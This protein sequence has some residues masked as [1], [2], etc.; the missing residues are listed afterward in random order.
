MFKKVTAIFLTFLINSFVFVNFCDANAMSYKGETYSKSLYLVN[1]DTGKVVYEKNARERLAPAST[2]KIMTYIVAVENCKDLN[3]TMVTVTQDITDK[4]RG[5]ESS[6]AGIKNGEV[7]SMY[8]LL[9][10]MMVPSGND[11]AMIIANYVSGSNNIDLFVE[12]MNNKATE[13]GC[14]NTHFKNPVGLHDDEHYTTAE[15]MYKITSYAMSLPLFTE[16]CSQVK[17]T[18]PQTNLQSERNLIST[19][20]MMLKAETKYYSKYVKGIKAGWHDQAGNCIV[21]SASNE[22]CDYICVALGAN[23]EDTESKNHDN[24]AMLDSKNLYD[25]VFTNFSLLRIPATYQSVKEVNLE[26][27]WNK[28]KIVLIPEKDFTVLLPKGAKISDISYSEVN[29]PDTL[30]APLKTT[31]VVGTAKVYYQGEEIAVTNLC[32][33]NPVDRNGY[34]YVLHL[35]KLAFTS[36]WFWLL[37]IIVFIFIRILQIKNRNTTRRMKHI[38]EK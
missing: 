30:Y 37:V 18:I 25:W 11:A 32:P 33:N 19:N 20:K 8:E 10:C 3:E 26:L 14:Q 29:S 12:M 2:T 35:I 27:T 16:I 36:F 23:L 1:T 13:L 6:L 31:D 21:T 17:H 28:D 24:G 38:R 34:L 7:L 9:N 15:D 5:T 4:L 22:A